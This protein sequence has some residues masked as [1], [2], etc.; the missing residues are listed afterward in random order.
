MWGQGLTRNTRFRLTR[1][2]PAEFS[3]RSSAY[4]S[5]MHTQTKPSRHQST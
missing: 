2:D 3:N 4:C 5:L 1:Y